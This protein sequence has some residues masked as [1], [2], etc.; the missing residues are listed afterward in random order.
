MTQLVRCEWDAR[1]ER[2]HEPIERDELIASHT[3]RAARAL[4]TRRY[5][6]D[7]LVALDPWIVRTLL[8]DPFWAE[9]RATMSDAHRS[10][11]LERAR[12]E[13]GVVGELYD[14]RVQGD[15][16]TEPPVDRRG[17]PCVC[18]LF[19]GNGL[20]ATFGDGP[21]ASP[22]RYWLWP[23]S[24]R[25]LWFDRERPGDWIADPARPVR[26]TLFV[27]N[28]RKR[29]TRAATR[30]LRAWR[31]RDLD[32]L[33]LLLVG[34]AAVRD[35]YERKLRELLDEEDLGADRA[36]SLGVESFDR[37]AFDALAAMIDESI[38]RT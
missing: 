22:M 38:D 9:L 21:L 3:D 27:C 32:A 15:V 34:D 25:E 10:A 19:D 37:A 12:R 11:L 6:L 20:D 36:L 29:L 1:C 31:E 18:V 16:P 30:P 2:C 4:L 35:G 28:T 17:R 23:S 8:T 24:K 13:R 7:C 5:H 14:R 33:S 26:A